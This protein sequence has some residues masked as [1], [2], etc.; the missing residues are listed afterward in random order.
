MRLNKFQKYWVFLLIALFFVFAFIQVSNVSA[1]IGPKPSFSFVFDFTA[2]AS[3]PEIEQVILYQCI[4]LDCAEREVL[5]EVPGQKFECDQEG[6]YVS[7][8]TGRAAWQIEVVL[9]DKTLLSKP[10][11]KEGFYS[12]YQITFTE[13]QLDIELISASERVGAELGT[14]PALQ[15]DSSRRAN[16]VIAGVLTLLIELPLAAL[17]L[18][19]FKA[20][21]K[22]TIWVLVGNLITIPIVWLVLPT[23]SLAVWLMSSLVLLTSTGIEGVILGLRGG[24]KMTW[25][26]A[27]IISLVINA[28]S[29]IFGLFIF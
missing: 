7:L 15:T 26:A 24:E 19:L 8:L 10:F 28:A 9:P 14:N 4:D 16:M 18:I 3:N 20:G 21:F 5:P 23:L 25:K 29:F 6:C 11:E 22:N 27:W 12:T 13:D 1:D 2:L 17:L